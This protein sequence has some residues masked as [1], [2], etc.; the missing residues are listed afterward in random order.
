MGNTF[1]NAAGIIAP[2]VTGYLLDQGHCPKAG[3]NTSDS[4]EVSSKCQSAWDYVF[5]VA[6]AVSCTGMLVYA[7]VGGWHPFYR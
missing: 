3:A 2:A 4:L 1:G 7:V 6:V 5:L